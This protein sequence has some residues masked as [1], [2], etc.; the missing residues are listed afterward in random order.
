FGI[1]IVPGERMSPFVASLDARPM[2]VVVNRELRSRGESDAAAGSTRHIELELPDG[3]V[4]RAG[5]HLG[6]I[7]HNSEQLV[8]R[9]ARRFGF[10]RDVFLRLHARDDRKTFLPVGE[11]VSLHALL[12]DYPE[13]QAVAS[14]GHIQTLAAHVECPFT[15]PKLEA[16]A[17]EADH[18]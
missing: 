10:E 7:P 4:Y 6:V 5:D 16:L 15:K 1:E 9:V 14:R 3:V 8:R 13:L 17:S 2:R 12:A 11:R 18:G